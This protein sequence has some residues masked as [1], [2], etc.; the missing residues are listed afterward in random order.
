[1]A[2]N[3]EWLD[4]VRE[5]AIEPE[6]AI[7]DTHHHLW[8]QREGRVEKRYLMDEIQRDLRTGHNIVSSVF[9]DCAAMY[10]AEGPEPMRPVGEVE[11]VNGIA[12]MAASGLYGKTRVAA[13]I[14]GH[15]DLQLG[16]QVKGVL[17]ALI[18]A[19]PQRFRGIRRTG[20]WDPDPSIDRGRGVTGP[21]LYLDAKFR[22]GFAELAALGLLFEGVCRHPQLGDLVDLA[23]AFPDTTLV[24]NHL[25]GVAGVGAYADKRDE[26]FDVWR[27]SIAEAAACP[28]VVVKLGGI[29]MIYSG[30]GWHTRARPPSSK[31]LC[32]ATRRYYETAIEH[33]GPQRCMF[34]S[35]FPVDKVSCSYP[36]LWNAFKRLTTDYSPNERALLFH[37]TAQRVYSL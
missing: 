30:F 32:D 5:A 11:F 3:D 36:V 6:M 19:A 31:E 24:L 37:D 8:D 28:N 18:D 20:A 33:F 15:A 9:V 10:R 27:K 23:R 29:N 13:A 17:E 2:T 7:C 12:A 16:S 1:M 14:I 21:G 26:V 4:Q 25:G 22:E 35:N 34:E